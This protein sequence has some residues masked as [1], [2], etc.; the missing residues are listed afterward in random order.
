[1]RV[2]VK[3]GTLPREKYTPREW[4]AKA[5]THP[6]VSCASTLAPYARRIST[7]STWPEG[8]QSE[9]ERETGKRLRHGEIIGR[10]ADDGGVMC[11]HNDM[12][13]CMRNG[14]CGLCSEFV[15]GVV[16]LQV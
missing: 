10:S 7:L 4:R 5:Y 8:D 11:Q 14:L 13:K 3:R 1:M 2:K 15:R 9:Q 16:A 12:G 6:C